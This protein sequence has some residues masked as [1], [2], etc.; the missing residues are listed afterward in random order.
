MKICPHCHRILGEIQEWTVPVAT[1]TLDLQARIAELENENA[2]LRIFRIEGVSLRTI[3]QTNDALRKRIAELEAM[4]P[5][6]HPYPAEKPPSHNNLLLCDIT[7]YV[8]PWYYEE[9]GILS[10]PHDTKLWAM[11]PNPPKEAK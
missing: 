1:A 3:K 10:L 11:M 2:G 9:D 5:T 7:N 6:W 8:Y 4:L